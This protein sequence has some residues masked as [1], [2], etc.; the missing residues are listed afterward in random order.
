[1]L[2]EQRSDLASCLAEL[3]RDVRDGRARFKRYRQFKMYNDP[4]LNP[5]LAAEVQDA[6]PVSAASCLAPPTRPGPGISG[7]STDAPRPDICVPTGTAELPMLDV[8]MPMMKSAAIMAGARLGVFEAL[9]AGPLDAAALAA[10]TRSHLEGTVALADFLVAIGYLVPLPAQA[11]SLAGPCFTLSDFARRW[12]SSGGRVDYTPGA[13]WNHEAWSM[14]G[15]LDVAVR[16]GRPDVSLWQ[17]MQQEPHLGP[18][19]S[20]YMHTFARHLGPD[21]VDR[22]PVSPGQTRLLDLGG[23]HGL[24][25]IGLCRAHSQLR[26]TVADWPASLTDTPTHIAQAGLAHRIDTLPGDILLEQ[27][28][29]PQ[30]FDLILYLSVGHNQDDAG[31]ARMLQAMARSLRA[32]GLIVVHDYLIGQPLNAFHA[33][34]R[35]TL[36]FETGTRTWS[37]ADYARWAGAAG[38]GILQRIDLDPVEKGSL[39]LISQPEQRA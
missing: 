2:Q 21:L 19:F 4:R 39:L 36:L 8:Y 24:H 17:R 18:L 38:L 35:L 9:S 32:G 5:V 30:G 28:V 37:E 14:M 22:V 27:W 12:F 16:Q 26:A 15:Q 11:G 31:N 33:A 34:F 7:V 1:V 20:R 6:R 3:M 23:S 13:L 10:A 25:S 29:E